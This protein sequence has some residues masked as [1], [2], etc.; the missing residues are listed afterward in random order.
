MAQVQNKF[1]L[2]RLALLQEEDNEMS[3]ET[4]KALVRRWVEEV[5]NTPGNL[6][7][8]DELFAPDYADYTNPPDWAPGR[9]GHRQI[10]ALYH[11]AFPDFHYTLEHEVSEGDMVVVR[12]TYHLTHTGEFFGIAPTGKQVTSTGMHLFRI[13]EGK[14]MEHWCNNDDLGV[15]RQLGV[16]S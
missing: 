1:N 16:I 2:D 6:A 13:A 15:M 10:V 7:V 5:L 9:E 12:G 8:I 14:F 11:A 4:N 3:F